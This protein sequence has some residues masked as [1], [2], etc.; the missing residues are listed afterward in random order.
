[1]PGDTAF[2][3]PFE[4]L[5]STSSPR[6]SSAPE[7]PSTP[8]GLDAGDGTAGSGTYGQALRSQGFFTLASRPRVTGLWCSPVRRL[9]SSPSSARDPTSPYTQDLVLIGTPDGRGAAAGR[10]ERLPHTGRRSSDPFRF[11]PCLGHLSDCCRFDL[12]ECWSNG[13]PDRVS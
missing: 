5:F 8:D 6:P 7:G 10:P 2:T 4:K 9:A 12:E 11:L 3:H 1:M 13:S